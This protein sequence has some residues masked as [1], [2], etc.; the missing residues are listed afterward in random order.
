MGGS[1]AGELEQA[2]GPPI[3]SGWENQPGG[4]D[5]HFAILFKDRSS[6]FEE[7][8][9]KSLLYEVACRPRQ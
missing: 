9:G 2:A 6:P 4:M 5:G 1:L 7:A 8:A 3:V